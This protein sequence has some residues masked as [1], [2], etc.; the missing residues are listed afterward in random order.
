MLVTL[1]I[2]PQ[3]SRNKKG[4]DESNGWVNTQKKEVIGAK[5]YI[6]IS[7]KIL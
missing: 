7:L 4:A 5:H 6:K 3:P 1:G 2:Q